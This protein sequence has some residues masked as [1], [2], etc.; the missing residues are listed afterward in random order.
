MHQIVSMNSPP[1]CCTRRLI[2][3]GSSATASAPMK[4]QTRPRPYKTR[5]IICFVCFLLLKQ[6]FHLFFI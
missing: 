2:V 3:Q 5:Y 1:R 4:E 6:R